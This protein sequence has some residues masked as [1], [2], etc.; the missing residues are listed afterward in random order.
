MGARTQRQC[1]RSDVGRALR[2]D[3]LLGQSRKSLVISSTVA[4]EK[5]LKSG[6]VVGE[7]G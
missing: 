1:L 3:C 4:G 6:G 5:T 2:L 7:G